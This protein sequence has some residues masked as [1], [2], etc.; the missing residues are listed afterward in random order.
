MHQLEGPGCSPRAACLRCQGCRCLGL[1]EQPSEYRGGHRTAPPSPLRCA[2]QEVA[3]SSLL[4]VSC[5]LLVLLMIQVALIDAKGSIAVVQRAL[6]CM[7]G[8]QLERDF[9]EHQIRARGTVCSAISLVVRSDRAQPDTL[10]TSQAAI[11]T[12]ACWAPIGPCGALS[13]TCSH[14]GGHRA[15]GQL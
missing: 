5:A 12:V 11:T 4:E 14:G 10:L 6:L 13:P 15:A 7:R 3:V 9:A 1:A 8:A 2:K